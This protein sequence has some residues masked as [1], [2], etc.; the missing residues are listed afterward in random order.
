MHPHQ[1]NKNC[2]RPEMNITPFSPANPQRPLRLIWPMLV[3][4]HDYYPQRRKVPPFPLNQQSEI[5]NPQ[6]PTPSY[7]KAKPC[8]ATPD[9]ITNSSLSCRGHINLENIKNNKTRRVGRLLC[10]P[11]S[12]F[13][14]DEPTKNRYYRLNKRMWRNWQTRRLQEP[15][16]S[17]P[18][19][20]DSSHPHYLAIIL[21]GFPRQLRT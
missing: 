10:P 13:F 20:F 5:F 7:G 4:Q 15:V 1:R 17:T 9:N 16:G 18:W 12:A 14:L 3:R 8:S 2:L 6:Y 21:A 11:D 19:R